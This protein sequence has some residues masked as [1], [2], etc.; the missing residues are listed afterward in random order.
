M[1]PWIVILNAPKLW[2]FPQS[3]AQLLQHCNDLCRIP[4]KSSF[5]LTQCKGF[6][7]NLT[8]KLNDTFIDTS[9]TWDSC[10]VRRRSN[11]SQYR[12]PLVSALQKWVLRPQGRITHRVDNT[13]T[14]APPILWSFHVGFRKRKVERND[15]LIQSLFVELSRL[16][17]VWSALGVKIPSS[18]ARKPTVGG[19]SRHCS[20]STRSTSNFGGLNTSINPYKPSAL[21]KGRR[22]CQAVYKFH[23][24]NHDR[25]IFAASQ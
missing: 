9:I 2:F 13:T 17:G 22:K 15:K 4:H 18:E 24:V 6:K 20:F 25:L 1:H 5:L 3:N 16:T 11:A 14:P 21:L 12:P 8:E 23:H 10:C 19:T 7:R